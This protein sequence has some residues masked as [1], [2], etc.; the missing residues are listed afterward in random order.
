MS[1]R[2][3]IGGFVV[4]KSLPPPVLADRMPALQTFGF[5]KLLLSRASGTLFMLPAN[6]GMS[7]SRLKIGRASVLVPI[8]CFCT[9]ALA[10]TNG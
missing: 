5:A 7:R 2:I 6:L 10:E 8:H 9:L 3:D 1:R 4:Q